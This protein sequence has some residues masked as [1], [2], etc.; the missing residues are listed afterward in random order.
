MLKQ[1][2]QPSRD[3]FYWH[4]PDEVTYLHPG[5][6]YVFSSIP[7]SSIIWIVVFLYEIVLLVAYKSWHWY[8]NIVLHTKITCLFYKLPHNCQN[9]QSITIGIST[10]V[11]CITIYISSLHFSLWYHFHTEAIILMHHRH[12]LYI[13]EVCNF[14]HMV[15]EF[16]M[17]EYCFQHISLLT[18]PTAFCRAQ[19]I[20]EG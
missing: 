5:W 3:A 12:A 14:P 15:L 4:L 6:Y 2:K 8:N 20:E 13:A 16:V 1:D 10:M 18:T 7:Y 11:C 9:I 19:G 17:I